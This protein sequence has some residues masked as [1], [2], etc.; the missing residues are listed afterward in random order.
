MPAAERIIQQWPAINKY[1]REEIPKNHKNE[2]QISKYSW[3]QK[4]TGNEI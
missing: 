4:K 1:F 2:L 3:L